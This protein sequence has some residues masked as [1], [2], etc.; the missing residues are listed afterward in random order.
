MLLSH[1]ETLFSGTDVTASSNSRS[2][3]VITR[4]SKEAIFFLD[5]TAVSG[6]N[7]TLDVTIRI[8]DAGTAKWHLL[9]TFTQK[10]SVTTDVGYVQ[11]G[12][13]DQVACDYAIGGTNTPTFTF[14]VTANL[15]DQ[16]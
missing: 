15:K 2:N 4:W 10:S 13:G 6:T 5:I 7:P 1:D 16:T 14:K 9:A 8:Y 3:P 11:Y 12:L